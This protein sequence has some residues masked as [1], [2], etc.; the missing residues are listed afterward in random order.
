MDILCKCGHKKKEH[1]L[2]VSPKVT[3]C[4]R[5]TH[6]TMYDEKLAYTELYKT[7]MFQAWH[8]Y[9]PD[10]L[11]YIETLAKERNLI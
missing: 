1:K 2:L 10:N 3:N 7:K 9:I 8:N 5:C 4:V 11:A 6:E